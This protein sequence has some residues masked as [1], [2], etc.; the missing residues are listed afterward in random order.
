MAMRTFRIRA[1][2]ASLV[3]TIPAITS[4][5]PPRNL[6]ALCITIAAPSSSG[7]C[8]TGVMKVESTRTGTPFA[9]R[10]ACSTST[11]SRVGLPGVSRTTRQVSG[12]TAPATP[13]GGRERHLV[14]EEAAGQQRVA[15]AVEGPDRHHVVLAGLARGEEDGGER[16]HA[17]GEGHRGLGALERGERRLVARHRR[18]VEAGVDE[19]AGRGAALRHRVDRGGGVG[20]VPGRVG[21]REVERGRVDADLA[22]VLAAGVDGEGVEGQGPVARFVRLLHGVMV[23]IRCILGQSN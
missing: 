1:A 7:R 19:A 20:Q 16:G 3:A 2:H 4:P 9:S 6:V 8:S 17:R 15:A 5:W 11:R 14:A 12:R 21:G 23:P 10:T 13:V 22:E 18:V